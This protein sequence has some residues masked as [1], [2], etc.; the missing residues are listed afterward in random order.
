MGDFPNDVF[1]GNRYHRWVVG[2]I[3]AAVFAVLAYLFYIAAVAIVCVL[4]GLFGHHRPVD[5]PRLALAGWLRGVARRRGRFQ[6]IGRAVSFLVSRRVRRRIGRVDAFLSVASKA[7]AMAL[8]VRVA[9]GVTVV[10]P[11]ANV[12]LNPP[13]PVH[14]VAFLQTA[15]G[16]LVAAAA[17]RGARRSLRSAALSSICWRSSPRCRAHSATSPPT[18]RRI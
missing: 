16:S 18:A 9:L 5:G 2:F 8:L 17:K 14:T 4:L 7:A 12:A 11:A 13:T 15:E 1:S 10:P 6:A 3:V